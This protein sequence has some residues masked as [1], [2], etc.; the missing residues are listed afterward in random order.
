M[1]GYKLDFAI[2]LVILLSRKSTMGEKNEFLLRAM[3]Y[4]K[5]NKK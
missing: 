4:L 5:T 3:I 1:V 2:A